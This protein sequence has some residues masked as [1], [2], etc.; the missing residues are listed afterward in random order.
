M[1]LVRYQESSWIF[2]V[3]R[4]Q[5]WHAYLN[6][7][8]G[9]NWGLNR[10]NI[11][12]PRTHSPPLLCRSSWSSGSKESPSMSARRWWANVQ[13]PEGCSSRAS[14]IRLPPVPSPRPG[15]WARPLAGR[16]L[17]P[18]CTALDRRNDQSRRSCLLTLSCSGQPARCTPGFPVS[19]TASTVPTAPPAVPT[20]PTGLGASATEQGQQG[21]SRASG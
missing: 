2:K 10:M 5:W 11:P 18:L 19:P 7:R 8:K 20:A 3:P 6:V 12:C 13:S 17:C 14:P 16:T 9:E 21:T 15:R 4:V 1:C